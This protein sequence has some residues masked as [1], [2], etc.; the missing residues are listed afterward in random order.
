VFGITMQVE[1][2]NHNLGPQMVAIDTR[3]FKSYRLL[4]A[5]GDLKDW[6]AD[7]PEGKYESPFIAVALDGEDLSDW[8]FVVADH[9]CSN[10]PIYNGLGKSVFKPPTVSAEKLACD[11]PGIWKSNFDKVYQFSVAAPGMFTGVQFEGKLS[12]EEMTLKGDKIFIDYRFEGKKGRG[13]LRLICQ[14]NKVTLKGT[15]EMGGKSGEWTFAKLKNAKTPQTGEELFRAN[16]TLC[17]HTDSKNKKVGPGLLG[18]FKGARLPDSGKPVTDE[19]VRRRI[20]KGGKEMPSFKHLKDAEL[21][22]IV[23]Y[24][25]SL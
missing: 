22:A 25:K 1:D 19:N 9:Q 15:F 14:E 10:S 20:V 4:P 7:F 16:C 17:H 5:Q 24:L 3:R 11:V 2:P 13:E 18:L 8:L 23:D 6:K 12:I 21:S